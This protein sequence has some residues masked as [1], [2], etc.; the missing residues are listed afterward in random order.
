MAKMN[1]LMEKLEAAETVEEI[2]E[3]KAEIETE[4]SRQAVIAEKSAILDSFKA[5]QPVEAKSEPDAGR[6]RR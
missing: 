6:F 1:E 5:E 4:K 2:N 3:V